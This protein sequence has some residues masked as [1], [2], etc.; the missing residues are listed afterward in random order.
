MATEKSL[1]TFVAAAANGASL[2]T[3]TL[4]LF[5]LIFGVVGMCSSGVCC[6]CCAYFSRKSARTRATSVLSA[7]KRNCCSTAIDSLP[8]CSSALEGC[9]KQNI[10]VASVS[11]PLQHKPSDKYANQ[12]IRQERPPA[13]RFP[14]LPPQP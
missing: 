12:S 4:F 3:Q 5:C 6:C 2:Q 14:P 10:T 9:G 11:R 8:S 13:I 1:A 7:A